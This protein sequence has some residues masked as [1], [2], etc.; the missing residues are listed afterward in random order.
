M[1]GASEFGLAVVVVDRHAW[2]RVCSRSASY[3]SLWRDAVRGANISFAR[4]GP[5]CPDLLATSLH[6]RHFPSPLLLPLCRVRSFAGSSFRSRFPT[7]TG[8]CCPALPTNVYER[9]THWVPPPSFSSPRCHEIPQSRLA[10]LPPSHSRRVQLPPGGVRPDG[11]IADIVQFDQHGHS[12]LFYKH[13]VPRVVTHGLCPLYTW[14]VIDVTSVDLLTACAQIPSPVIRMAPK[15]KT[16]NDQF[17]AQVLSI[18]AFI[19]GLHK[20]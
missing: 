13:T 11:G 4:T 1:L 2:Q 7:T 8:W 12:R 6:C 19:L 18:C 20:Y 16:V 17:S 15:P 9:S 14:P 10:I 5:S 3:I